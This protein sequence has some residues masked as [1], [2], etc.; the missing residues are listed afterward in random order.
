MREAYDRGDVKTVA[1]LHRKFGGMDVPR[2]EDG[3]RDFSD[4]DQDEEDENGEPR[5]ASQDEDEDDGRDHDH[6]QDGEYL[7]DGD[8][9][10][11]TTVIGKEASG[12]PLEGVDADSWGAF[13]DKMATQ[14][15][16]Y[17]GPNHVGKF[18]Q[19]KLRLKQLGIDISEFSADKQYEAFV[20]DISDLRERGEPLI[21]AWECHPVK[22]DQGE[23]VA[24]LSGIL[25]VLKSAGI[26]KARS[27]FE[28]EADRKKF[29]KTT[30]M[31]TKANGAF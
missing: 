14:P 23:Q 7:P 1:K 4:D 8:P 13:V 6:E 17:Q 20:K 10:D 3:D 25:A 22:I 29:A 24:T 27:W 31:F 5:E 15:E 9:D 16:T 28:S 12:S 21:R 2:I 11:G 18:H 26:E 30:E 19:S